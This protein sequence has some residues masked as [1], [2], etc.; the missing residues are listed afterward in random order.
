MQW[1]KTTFLIK[2]ACNLKTIHSTIVIVRLVQKVESVD[3]DLVIVFMYYHM[4][5]GNDS[6]TR[7]IFFSARG[8]ATPLRNELQTKLYV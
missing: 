4:L 8:N 6:V 7:D 5:L 3:L 2:F 1:E